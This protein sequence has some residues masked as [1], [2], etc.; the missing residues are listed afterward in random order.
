MF[1]F[2]LESLLFILIGLQAPVVLSALADEPVG[3]LLMAAAAVSA[4][5]IVVRLLFVLGV[6]ALE[7]SWD[8]RRERRSFSA[9]ERAVV[10]WSGMRGAVSL[11]AALAIPLETQAGAPFP[12]RELVLFLALAVIGVTLG[13]PGADA[14]GPGAA[15]RGPR[16]RAARPERE[17][18]RALS[19]GRG[20]AR[21]RHRPLLRFRRAEP[22]SRARARDVRPARSSSSPGECRMPEGAGVRRRPAGGTR[23]RRHLLDVERA[24][25]LDLRRE[26][27]VGMGVMR[28]VERDLDL[29]EERLNRTPVAVT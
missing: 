18:G 17:G 20:R 11:A 16:R 14:P 7:S 22:G 27:R 1:I 15:A 29:E 26:G 19:H 6:D 13:A 21:A 25:L 9:R 4:T 5:V 24:A 23:L 3:E 28:E 2:V 10:G 12:G 8:A